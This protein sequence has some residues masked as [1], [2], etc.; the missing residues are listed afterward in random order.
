MAEQLYYEDIAVGAEL[1]PLI[2]HPT[3]E[4][5]VRYAGAVNDYARIHYDYGYARHRGFPGVIVHGLFKAACM[6]QLVTDWAG[7][8]AWVKKASAQYRG[9]DEPFHD[10]A[11]KGKVVD[12]YIRE[13]ERLV[14]VEV[15]TE[16]DKGQV[17]TKG[18][19]TILFPCRSE[20]TI[21]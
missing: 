20:E 15:W 3:T 12:K 2:K 7:P 19:A 4:Q 10:M 11:C 1:P 14:D 18:A 5:L 6:G 17:T 21:P 16:N 13:G 9:I 8:K